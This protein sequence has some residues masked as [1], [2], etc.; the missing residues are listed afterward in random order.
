M[1]WKRTLVALALLIAAA[2]LVAGRG[3]AADGADV[4]AQQVGAAAGDVLLPM[5][6]MIR[7]FQAPLPR[8]DVPGDGSAASRD[9]LVDAFIAA[10]EDSSAA[11][12]RSLRLD[13]AE[14]AWLYYPGSRYVARP[15]ELPP[16][17]LWLLV[18]QNGLKGE[19]RLL[20]YF[21]GRPLDIEGYSCEDE[22]RREAQNTFWEQC[23]ITIRDADGARTMRLFGSIMERSGR[24]KFVSFANDL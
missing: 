14:F 19:T 11:R 10:V 7:R 23:R 24:Y 22:P 1:K 12:L 21:G 4:A 15:Y 3:S 8:V 2:W 5:P 18:D 9:A 6:E 16:G 13:I 17:T 20:R